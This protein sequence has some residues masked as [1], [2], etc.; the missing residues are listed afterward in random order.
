MIRIKKMGYKK[1]HKSISEK[2]LVCLLDALDGFTKVDS[3]GVE[4]SKILLD[5]GVVRDGGNHAA[6][7][8]QSA[9]N[10]GLFV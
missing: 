4:T 8:V 1:I 3:Q 9:Q 5:D 7:F 2:L 10:Y 6:V